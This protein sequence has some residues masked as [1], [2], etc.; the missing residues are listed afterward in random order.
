MP[1][2]SEFDYLIAHSRPLLRM[3]EV[4]LSLRLAKDAIYALVE[5][6]KL[7]AHQDGAG[8]VYRI[9]RRSVLSYLATTALYQTDDWAHTVM[10]LTK[11]L[12]PRFRAKLK[13]EL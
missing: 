9:T 8:S 1:D 5:E 4:M 12:P 7:E 2:Q 11:Q 6:G 10:T 3:H 13:S